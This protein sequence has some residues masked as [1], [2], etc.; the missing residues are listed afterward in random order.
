[1][2]FGVLY[3]Y[4]Q[5]ALRSK[6]KNSRFKIQFLKYISL[7]SKVIICVDLVGGIEED[8]DSDPDVAPLG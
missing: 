5:N 2:G 4:K 1:M 8:K 6:G 3:N 7:N